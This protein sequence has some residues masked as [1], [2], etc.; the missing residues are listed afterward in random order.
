MQRPYTVSPDY[1][2]LGIIIHEMITGDAPYHRTYRIDSNETELT[3]STSD[4]I[5][6]SSKHYHM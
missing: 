5:R 2:T 3:K 4:I 1:W 6:T